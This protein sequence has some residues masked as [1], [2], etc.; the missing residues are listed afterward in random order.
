MERSDF[1]VSFIDSYQTDGPDLNAVKRFYDDSN[2]GKED[3]AKSWVPV[4]DR[5]RKS[6][7]PAQTKDV[8]CS[9]INIGFTRYF[10]TDDT[11][12]DLQFSIDEADREY[13]VF[14][15]IVDRAGSPI[16]SADN[17]KDL[18][19]IKIVSGAFIAESLA[20]DEAARK[21]REEA[22]LA[23]ELAGKDGAMHS[24]VA[25]S[26][27]TTTGLAVALLAVL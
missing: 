24:L 6:C 7:Q 15:W 23:E 10:T 5:L 14:G 27:S 2:D 13:E 19:T 26:S 4:Y 20:A 1:A 3:P 16:I 22:K 11:W 8:T 21:A 17:V 12:Q 18:K 25:L 9:I